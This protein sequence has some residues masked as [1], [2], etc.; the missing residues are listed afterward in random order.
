MSTSRILA[1]AR[2]SVV[3]VAILRVPVGAVA[4]VEHPYGVREYEPPLP[5]V[6]WWAVVPG[7]RDTIGWGAVPCWYG[8][9]RGVRNGRH[10]LDREAWH[11]AAKLLRTVPAVYLRYEK[12]LNFGSWRWTAVEASSESVSA[13]LAEQAGAATA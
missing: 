5:D 4:V 11:E 12:Q 6:E 10:R 3:E 13:R 1:S 2:P 7:S 9:L 8:S